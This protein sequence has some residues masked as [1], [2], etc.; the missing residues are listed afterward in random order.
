MGQFEIS[1]PDSLKLLQRTTVGSTES[2][3]LLK[4]Q[5][6]LKME[7]MKLTSPY[8]LM[9]MQESSMMQSSALIKR[10]KTLGLSVMQVIK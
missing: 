9:K 5:G 10:K 3:S 6:C 7:L 2:K 8:S 4:I 1:G